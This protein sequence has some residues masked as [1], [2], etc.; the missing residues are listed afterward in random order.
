MI[1]SFSATGYRI[2]SGVNE[3]VVKPII[4]IQKTCKAMS[5]IEQLLV[6]DKN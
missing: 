4:D 5:R 6:R 1:R 2:Y 3:T